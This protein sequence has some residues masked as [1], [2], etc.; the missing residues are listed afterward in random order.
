MSIFKKLTMCC[1]LLML[2]IHSVA[3]AKDAEDKYKDTKIEATKVA[4]G[5]YMLT[6]QG[7]NIG[8]SAG[9]DGIFMIDD[10]FAP[11]TEKIKAAIAKISDKPI[12][13]VINTHWHFDHTGG[14]EN[15]GKDGVVLVAHDN[16]RERMS[17]D[18]FIKAF[19]KKI[20]YCLLYFIQ[21]ILYIKLNS[22][23]SASIKSTALIFTPKDKFL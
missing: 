7:G 8:I 9:E 15:L 23:N 10:Q 18:G 11:L 4:D 19:S 2:S 21:R 16:V 3:S 22:R 14:N 17:K 5:I 13:F 1:F 12:R 6:G 20:P